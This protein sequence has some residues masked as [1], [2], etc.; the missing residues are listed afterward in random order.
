MYACWVTQFCLTLCNPMTVACQASLLK[1]FS[2]QEYW[3]GWPCP[4]SRDLP[5]PV[6]ESGFCRIFT[7]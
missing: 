2:R 3:S 1:G 4:F 6:M 7:V 5:N